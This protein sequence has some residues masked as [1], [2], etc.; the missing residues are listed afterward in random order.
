MSDTE[1]DLLYNDIDV[2]E[3]MELLSFFNFSNEDG[4][5]SN[6]FDAWLSHGDD[7]SSPEIDG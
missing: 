3:N 6:N 2:E 1:L 7:A 5:G 4:E